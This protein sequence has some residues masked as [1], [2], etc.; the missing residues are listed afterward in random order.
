MVCTFSLSSPRLACSC[1]FSLPFKTDSWKCPAAYNMWH[2]FNQSKEQQP[3]SFIYSCFEKKWLT[4]SKP[5]GTDQVNAWGQSENRAYKDQR[6]KR[7][8]K[9]KKNLIPLQSHSHYL[10]FFPY[11]LLSWGSWTAPSSKPLVMV[12]SPKESLLEI[13]TGQYQNSCYFWLTNFVTIISRAISFLEWE[14]KTPL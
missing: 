13:Q 7:S 12:S 9:D 14:K 10:L 6:E 2:L 11:D 8:E 5:I 1:S 3:S 4:W